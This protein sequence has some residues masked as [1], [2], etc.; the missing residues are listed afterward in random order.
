MN[1]ILRLTEKVF[2]WIHKLANSN[3]LLPVV[4]LLILLFGFISYLFFV[5]IKALIAASQQL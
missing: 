3:P 2:P 1:T 4:V 5:I